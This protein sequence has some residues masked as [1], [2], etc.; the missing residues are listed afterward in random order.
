MSPTKLL[1]LLTFHCL[2]GKTAKR[3]DERTKDQAQIKRLIKDSN[4]FS[5][6]D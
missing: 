4:F 1:D 3:G 6:S 2:K 5:A